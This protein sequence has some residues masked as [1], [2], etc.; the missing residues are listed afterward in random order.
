M[1]ETTLTLSIAVGITIAAAVIT[2]VAFTYGSIE[3]WWRDYKFKRDEEKRKKSPMVKRFQYLAGITSSYEDET[4]TLRQRF[5][6]IRSTAYNSDYNY[7]FN[8]RNM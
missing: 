1:I 4:G 7:R 3:N 8:L 6:R 2:I 5:N